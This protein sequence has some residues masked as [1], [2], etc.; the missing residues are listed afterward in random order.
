MH[1]ANTEKGRNSKRKSI[2][3]V[4]RPKFNA[5]TKLK[6]CEITPLL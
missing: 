1:K 3:Q 2:E 4:V 5:K 6:L